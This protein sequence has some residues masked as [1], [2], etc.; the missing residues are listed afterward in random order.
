MKKQKKRQK[1]QKK[2]LVQT[3]FGVRGVI[4]NGLAPVLVTTYGAA[5]GTYLKKGKVV[6]GSDTLI[7]AAL[8]LSALAENGQTLS[9]PVGTF[10]RYLT[11]KSKARL[12]DD[13][14]RRLGRFDKQASD[15]L[16]PTKVDHRDGLRFNFNEGWLQLRKSNTEPIFR[17]IIETSDRKLTANLHRKTIRFFK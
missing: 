16:G 6:V 10:P 2:Q 14:D 8:V 17:L 1:R 12:P 7:G 9:E 5:F 15:I 13:F 11:T 3:V 4:G